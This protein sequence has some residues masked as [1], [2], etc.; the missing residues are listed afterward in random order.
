MAQ[1]GRLL[2]WTLIAGVCSVASAQQPKEIVQEAV[3]AE[4]AASAADHTHWLY[5]EVDNKPGDGTVQWVAET[6]LGD[7]NR[8]LKK[9]DHSLSRAEQKSRMDAFIHDTAAQTKARKSSQ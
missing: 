9:D 7:L 8:V 3:R 4:L 2:L 5:Y 1:P 6:S